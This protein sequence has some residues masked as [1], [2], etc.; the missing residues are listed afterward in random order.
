VFV[1]AQG[2][3]WSWSASTPI[4]NIGGVD[5]VWYVGN[6]SNTCPGVA[7][8]NVPPNQQFITTTSNPNPPPISVTYTTCDL[9]FFGISAQ[10][11]SAL[12]NQC[13]TLSLSPSPNTPVPE[14]CNNAIFLWFLDGT[15]LTFTPQP[16]VSLGWRCISW[17]GTVPQNPCQ[18]SLTITLSSVNAPYKETSNYVQWDTIYVN[19]VDSKGQLITSTN[20]TFSV[21]IDSVTYNSIGGV[22]R[23]NFLDI[24]SHSVSS[25]TC[26]PTP[27]SK[28][29][30][31][32]NVQL[33]GYA[34]TTSYVPGSGT[35]CSSLTMTLD[36]P[37]SISVN[38]GTYGQNALIYWYYNVTGQLSVLQLP[39][40]ILAIV[41]DIGSLLVY[42]LYTKQKLS[43]RLQRPL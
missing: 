14:L 16:D 7:V 40:Y 8:P 23:S 5:Y 39:G 36:T 2:I 13:G 34:V 4:S 10:L 35:S 42:L 18:S 33:I 11:S 38:L 26:S 15:Q 19:I 41:I 27:T 20:V 28:S 25:P 12:D 29:N 17:S 43:I 32:G 3:V 37:S 24:G 6:N 30:L 21:L 1:T 22:I 31:C 9:V